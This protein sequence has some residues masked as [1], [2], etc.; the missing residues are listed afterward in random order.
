MARRRNNRAPRLLS[1]GGGGLERVERGGPFHSLV[2]PRLAQNLR[3][4][5]R[6][7][8]AQTDNRAPDT[9]WRG[10]ER[11]ARLVESALRL[12]DCLSTLF[13]HARHEVP[14]VTAWAICRHAR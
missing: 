12:D 7:V 11:S 13:A 2:L 14:G 4:R 9:R 1:V 3:N 10:G 6:P 8:D 5:V